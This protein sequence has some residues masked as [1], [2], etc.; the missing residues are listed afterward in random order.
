MMTEATTV[1][2]YVCLSE[3][4]LKNDLK[5]SRTTA[6]I[7]PQS[8]AIN[9]SSLKDSQIQSRTYE[10]DMTSCHIGEVSVLKSCVAMREAWDQMKCAPT[11]AKIR[12]SASVLEANTLFC[13]LRKNRR[14]RREEEVDPRRIAWNT[15]VKLSQRRIRQGKVSTQDQ[16]MG[17]CINYQC[18][19]RLILLSYCSCIYLTSSWHVWSP[20]QFLS[21]GRVCY[22]V[23]LVLYLKNDADRVEVQS[24]C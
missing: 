2:P 12:Y 9:T 6:L 13:S 4:N 19:Q 24:K 15:F 5:P 18:M 16:A 14:Y 11:D 20:S 10:T 7:M 17:R 1:L 8:I 21:E 23:H 22:C 3:P